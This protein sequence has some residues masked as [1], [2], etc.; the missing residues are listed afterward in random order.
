[1]LG[2][3]KRRIYD[4]TNALIG[5]NV[6][7]KQGKSS[8]KWMW[9]LSEISF[10]RGGQMGTGPEED[11]S[12][13]AVQREAIE[14]QCN[15]LDRLIRDFSSYL[16]NAVGMKRFLNR[17]TTTIP[18]SFSP[19]MNSSILVIRPII[20]ILVRQ[21]LLW[22]LLRVHGGDEWSCQERMSMWRTTR[23]AETTRSFYRHLAVRFEP[24]FCHHKRMRISCTR[25]R[26]R[27]RR[28]Q[29]RC[30]LKCPFQW[31]RRWHLRW[32]LRWRL[33][34]LHRLRCVIVF[35]DVDH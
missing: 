7:Q 27:T 19:R 30:R 8:Y 34:W 10:R 1:M 25:H 23:K 9:V 32:W 11:T 31:C 13:F 28:W 4:I 3:E 20:Q 29:R 17:S 35:R 15:E 12:S 2:V 21:S 5:A 14:K 33:S 18:T 6:L 24:I 26:F 22:V 16:E